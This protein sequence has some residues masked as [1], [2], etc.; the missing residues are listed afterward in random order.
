MPEV[1]F[2]GVIYCC[3]PVCEQLEMFCALQHFQRID[4]V[5]EG[6]M[7]NGSPQPLFH[8]SNAFNL[9]STSRQKCHHD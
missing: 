1:P 8:I 2:L 3:L 4:L 6:G 7:Q 5:K 9:S